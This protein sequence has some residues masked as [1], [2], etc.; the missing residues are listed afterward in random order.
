M[1]TNSTPAGDFSVGRDLAGRMPT[2][3][4]E[5]LE[6]MLVYGDVDSILRI[7]ETAKGQRR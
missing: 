5:T 7:E 6:I 4:A 1:A 3:L 2:M